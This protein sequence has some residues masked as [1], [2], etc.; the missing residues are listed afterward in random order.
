M[1]LIKRTMPSHEEEGYKNWSENLSNSVPIHYPKNDDDIIKLILLAKERNQKLRVIGNSHSASPIV[2]DNGESLMLIHLKEYQREPNIHIDY[3]EMT[4]TVNAGWTLGQLYDYLNEGL[5]FLE[6]QPASGAFTVGGVLGT[7][8]H[9]GR[10]GASLIA[11]SVVN[12]T[13]I[14]HKGKILEKNNLD[15]DFDLYRL[16]MGLYGVVTSV[17]FHIHQ[18]LDVESQKHD[19]QAFHWV[20]GKPVFN[21][22]DL[23][24]FFW[25]RIQ[26]CLSP[27]NK[28]HQEEV[29]STD[30]TE[31]LRKD[32]KTFTGVAVDEA[33]PYDT[34][35]KKKAR[36]THGF[37]DFHNNR[38]LALDW[39]E[40]R[41]IR[42]LRLDRPEARRIVKF[43]NFVHR[44]LVPKYRQKKNYLKLMGK[45]VRMNISQSVNFKQWDD[46]DMLWVKVGTRVYFM[47]YFI[48]VY[49][50]GEKFKWEDV[51]RPFEIIMETIQKFKEEKRSFT[52]DF[53][54]DFRFVTSTNRTRA[55]PVYSEGPRKVFL[56]MEI[57]CGPSNLELD[58][59]KRKNKFQDRLYK[60]FY[61]F[62]SM[63]EEGWKGLGA[64]PHWGKM[65]GFNPESDYPF[66]PEDTKKL[67]PEDL[68]ER[69]VR[70]ASSLFYNKFVET[71]LEPQ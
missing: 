42:K 39:K 62:F 6:T 19:Y 53:P 18:M 34:V 15:R 2:S 64:V 7:P 17:T 71:M 36:Y 30:L 14:N 51:A 50:E 55:S 37:L 5:L 29:F 45:F 67:L 54:T 63:V 56:A 70:R 31:R 27:G 4:V 44:V 9:G 40:K 33:A 69:I 47:A 59:V 1:A 38:I 61:D 32:L 25:E 20:D 24:K 48:P 49:V 68:K 11:D 58:A 65:Y 57:L 60:D 28:I 41:K 66:D 8:V 43:P 10:L 23:K 35:L 52:I 16:N 13:L 12:L 26:Y 21:K 22:A 46:Q 3:D